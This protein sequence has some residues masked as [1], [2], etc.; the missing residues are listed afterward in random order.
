MGASTCKCGRLALLPAATCEQCEL[1]AENAA[2][3]EENRKLR[4]AWPTAVS[5]L[6]VPANSL[7]HT[8]RDEW[9]VNGESAV[10]AWDTRDEAINAAA[11]ITQAADAAK[12][13]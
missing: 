4:K 5:S 11:G 10:V 1:K 12:G 7:V 9:I 8:R 2:L 6:T 3:R 13:K